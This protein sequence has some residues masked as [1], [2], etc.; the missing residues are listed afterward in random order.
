MKYPA[1]ESSTLEFKQEAPAKQQIIKTIIGFCNMHGGTLVVG[2]DDN[3]EILGIDESLVEQLMEDIHKSIY[4]SCTPP[5]LPSLHIQRIDDKIL[6]LIPSSTL[7]S[8]RI[9]MKLALFCTTI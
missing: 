5:I 4:A 1:N 6:L 2:V 8:M 7:R 3:K 9:D